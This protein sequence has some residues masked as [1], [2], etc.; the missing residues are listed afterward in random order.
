LEDSSRLVGAHCW[1]ERRLFEIAGSWVA[2]T[3]EVEAKLML[4]R[5]SQHH[6]WRARQWWDRL[7]VLD[8]V[9]RDQLVAPTGAAVAEVM[10]ALSGLEG[11][12]ARL[13]GLYRVALARVH[14]SYRAHQA[15]VSEV[16]DGSVLRTLKITGRDVLND[17]SEGEARLQSLLG[18]RPAVDEAAAAVTRLERMLAAG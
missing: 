5:H 8:D 4:D 7:P 9:D 15:L 11:T 2:T 6:A 12:V 17:W 18:E 10:S 14:A 3:P 1:V 16:S 13:A